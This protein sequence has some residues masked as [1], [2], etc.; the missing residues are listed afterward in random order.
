[1]LP[2][3]SVVRL[4]STTNLPD[5]ITNGGR[6]VELN[7]I[8]AIQNSASKFKM[9]DCFLKAGVK[10]AEF[11]KITDVKAKLDKWD[12]FP[13]VAKINFGSRGI[14]MKRIDTLIDLKDFLKTD[15]AGYYFEKFYNYSREYR[16]HVTSEGCFYTCRKVLKEET[17]KDDRWYR[18]DTNC[19]WIM[20][21]NPLFDKPSNWKQIEAECVKA[22]KAVGL[23]IGA[24]DVK[25]QSAKDGKT[26][27]RKEIDFIIIEINSAPSFGDV[28]AEKYL[29]E[30]PKVLK[31]KHGILH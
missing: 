3:K 6:R 22:L 12:M 14:G 30:I 25:V 9:K 28:T 7:T 17:P 21:T 31:R 10:T 1:M 2:F 19:N 11:F 15:R 24:C 16:L 8:D 29:E 23:D 4:G 5:T 20:E 26:K 13:L 18:N 27:E